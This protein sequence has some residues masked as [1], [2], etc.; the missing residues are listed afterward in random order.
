MWC[1]I[2]LRLALAHVIGDFVLQTDEWCDKKMKFRLK[3]CHLYIH[4]F[5]IFLLTWCAFWNWSA[6]WIAA[7]MGVSHLAI[8][9]LKKRNGVWS[10]FWDQLG[11]I[12]FIIILGYVAADEGLYGNICGDP[13]IVTLLLF[14]LINAK[15]ANILIKLLLREYSVTSMENNNG[16]E[17]D[18]G[19]L[20]G[21]LIG[22]LERWL[23]IIF[24]LCGQFEAIG[25]L[26]AAKSIIRYKEGAIGKTEY[27]LA[28]TLLSVLIAVISG[29]M[30]SVL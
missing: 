4:S 15:P 10:F 8:D 25:F 11:H 29:L 18:T 27:V 2:V 12:V 24:I 23:I 13:K 26:I 22:N 3:S 5:I 21:K 28:G 14:L 6:W 19:M 16:E 1:E 20:S 17:C 30:L 9:A 7:V